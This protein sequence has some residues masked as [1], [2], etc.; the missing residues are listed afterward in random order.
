MPS[1]IGHAL[2]GIATGSLF[3]RDAGWRHVA[4]F[5]LAGVFADVDLL[6]PGPHRGPLHSLGAAFL[7]LVVALGLKMR[8]R[9]AAAIATAYASHTLLDWLGADSAPP[10]GLMA[11][12]PLSSG[13]Y[14]SNLNVFSSVDRRYWLPGVWSGNAIS[15]A[16]EVVILAPPASLITW[17]RRRTSN[18][19]L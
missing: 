6:L 15:I 3:S 13:Y 11:L 4:V 12:W 16:W 9:L 18:K 2:G 10:R 17:L 14:I 8:P 19:Q 5:A 7:V 1:P